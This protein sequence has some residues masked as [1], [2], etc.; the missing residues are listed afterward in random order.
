[1]K[2]K[3]QSIIAIYITRFLLPFI[4]AFGIY[5]QLNSAD[6]P[7][8]GFQAGVL[9]ASALILHSIVFGSQSTL[10]VIPFNFLITFACFGMSIYLIA[11]MISS[12]AGKTFLDYGILAD[13]AIKGQKLGIFSIELGVGCAV[14][15]TICIIFYSFIQWEK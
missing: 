4:F 14:F 8:G 3:S 9:M 1:M 6:S 15:S 13:K 2:G 10:K 7:G 11:G 5:V 12:L